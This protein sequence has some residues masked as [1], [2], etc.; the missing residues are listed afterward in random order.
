M[1][2]TVPSRT[3]R[4]RA[5]ALG[6]GCLGCVVHACTLHGGWLHTPSRL[7]R[8]VHCIVSSARPYRPIA[9]SA[10]LRSRMWCSQSNDS[11]TDVRWKHAVCA[12]AS[13]VRARVSRAGM[14]SDG[15]IS[16]VSQCANVPLPPCLAATQAPRA[17]RASQRLGAAAAVAHQWSARAA[18]G[19][20]DQ[21]NAGGTIISADGRPR[22]C[23]A[24]DDQSADAVADD[25]PRR[26][27]PVNELAAKPTGKPLRV[28]CARAPPRCLL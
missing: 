7:M 13:V 26:P 10:V 18:D 6:K 15:A 9:R 19:T 20:A 8:A 23:R 1:R 21:C 14:G 5:H 28:R 3:Q 27:S 22:A 16:N 4:P 24:A 25:T 17:R 12:C 2:L 11:P